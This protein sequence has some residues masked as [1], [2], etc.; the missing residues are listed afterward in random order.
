VP[1]PLPVPPSPDDAIDAT[2][3]IQR[4]AALT[5]V[6]DDLPREAR[7]FARWRARGAEPS[8]LRGTESRQAPRSERD[9]S[10]ARRIWPLRLGRPPGQRLPTSRRPAHTI[11]QL[12]DDIHGLA[13]WALEAPDTS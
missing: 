7:R 8:P 1:A 6:L 5:R 9:G 2:R 12:L 10:G 3:L 13:F 11:H 4:L